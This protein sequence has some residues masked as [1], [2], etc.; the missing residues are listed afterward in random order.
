MVNNNFNNKLNFLFI[1]KLNLRI[2]LWSKN[3]FESGEKAVKNALRMKTWCNWSRPIVWITQNGLSKTEHADVSGAGLVPN[4]MFGVSWLC[5]FYFFFTSTFCRARRMLL[6][7]AG[8][9]SL[10]GQV[11]Q[12][13]R[14][15][16]VRKLD[17][18][19]RQRQ[20]RERAQYRFR[21][22]QVG[23]RVLGRPQLLQVSWDQQNHIVF[24][25]FFPF[26]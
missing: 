8:E 18:R 19:R 13:E 5:G 3:S 10:R 12:D 23:E 15:L 25:L 14:R 9:R 24:F 22:W 17:H 2:S 21:V 1:C 6:P 20:T 11:E 16:R 4:A 26:F 7:D